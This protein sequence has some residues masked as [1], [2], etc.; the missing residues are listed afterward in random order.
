MVDETK[1]QHE[2]YAKRSKRAERAMAQLRE[3]VAR[4]M[5][6]IAHLMPSGA[7]LPSD[8]VTRLRAL[9]VE[10][11][12]H[13]ASSNGSTAQNEVSV[14]LNSLAQLVRTARIASGK[15]QADFASLAGVGRRFLSELENGKP[16]L[17][18][19]KVLQVLSAAGI[20]LYA[21]KR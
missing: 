3:S 12:G 5:A 6:T 15:S 18:I 14:E 1:N 4:N 8:P 13:I 19:G 20:D 2:V 17:E 16:T 21:R 11:V 10:R 7:I 9:N